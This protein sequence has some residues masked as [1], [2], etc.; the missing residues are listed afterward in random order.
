LY[1][2][3]AGMVGREP[4]FGNTAWAVGRNLTRI[5]ENQN[6]TYTQLSDRLRDQCQWSINAVGIR[7][8][9]E[10]RRRVTVDDLVALALALGVSPVTLL[11]PDT[12]SDDQLIQITG[13][14][15][16]VN[17]RV[18]WD[19]LRAE[20]PL[21]S[22]RGRTWVEFNSASWPEWDKGRMVEKLE[23]KKRQQGAHIA[24]RRAAKQRVSGRGDD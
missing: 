20:E 2:K 13:V 12:K 10:L 8:I 21:F 5:R 16:R 19:W 14:K 24:G 15:D 9:E 3:M 23:L 18:L 17:A 6:L 4:D 7:R 22:E 11:M 1:V